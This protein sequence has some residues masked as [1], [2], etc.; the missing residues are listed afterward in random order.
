MTELAERADTR[1]AIVEA[2]ARLLHEGGA[3]AVTT[4]GVA[5]AAG[6]Q[7]PAIYRLFGDK[8]GLLDAVAEHELARFVA[9]KAARVEAARAERVDPVDDLRTGWNDQIGFGLEHPAVFA[10]LHDPARAPLS[11]AVRLGWDL[12]A[13]RVHR[14]A[15]AGRLRVDERR[16]ADLI[17][18]A[19]TGVVQTLVAT[20]PG[21]RDPGLADAL[22]D[23]VLAQILV[24]AP[25]SADDPVR[26]AA[27]GLRAAVADLPPLS[28]A[29]RGLL[30]DWLDR[31]V[32]ARRSGA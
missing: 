30:A 25:T 6:V 17:H 32:A 24:D 27:V 19:G 2:A 12:L 9:A 21:R 29:E 26:T 14:V 15:A 18:A 20:P 22:L 31:V 10:L 13:E 11:P 16:A 8:D 5:E 28:T 1:T 3:A 4:R 7:A 23:A